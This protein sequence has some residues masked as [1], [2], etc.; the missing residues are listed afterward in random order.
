M[1]S[2]I[3][4]HARQAP[5]CELWMRSPKRVKTETLRKEVQ[6]TELTTDLL[7]ALGAGKH[8]L[9]HWSAH[10]EELEFVTKLGH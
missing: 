1:Q 2:N 5:V 6:A 7:E 4:S 8:K 9:D 3:A 10:P